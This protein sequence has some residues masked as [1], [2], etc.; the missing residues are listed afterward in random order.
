MAHASQIFV[1]PE[2]LSDDEA[3][4]AEPMACALHAALRSPLSEDDTVAVIGAG[5]LGLGVVA[6]ID[7]LHHEH[8]TKKPHRVIVGARYSHQRS[9]AVSLG[10]DQVVEP[11]QLSR[12]VRSATKA[13]SIGSSEQLTEL[14]GGA[15]ITFDCVGSAE[16]IA[17]ALRI[18]APGGRIILVGM[19]AKAS[20][21]LAPLWRR[22]IELIGAYAYGV[23]SIQGQAVATFDLAFSFIAAKQLGALVSAHYPL[24]RF[25]EALAHAGQA[26]SRG[27]TKIVFESSRS[28]K[29]RKD[30]Q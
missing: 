22:E 6:A 7:F 1:V 25:E 30:D 4:M 8:G 21:D 13:G 29:H 16:S 11:K 12:A 26:G 3:V 14:T 23:E 10:A 2:A 9:L 5:T 20:I 27:A 18:T 28:F 15:T 17:E 24:E 19:P